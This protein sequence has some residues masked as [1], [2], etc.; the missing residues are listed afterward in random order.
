MSTDK[1][2]NETSAINFWPNTKR[3][4]NTEEADIDGSVFF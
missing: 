2:I 4:Y 1:S 3:G